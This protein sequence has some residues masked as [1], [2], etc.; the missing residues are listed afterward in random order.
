MQ[1]AQQYVA[2]QFNP[3]FHVN[4]TFL[5]AAALA[6]T[7]APAFAA[8]PVTRKSAVAK[9]VTPTPDWTIDVGAGVLFTP[10]FPGAKDNKVLPL[11]FFAINY[12]D[13]VFAS[14]R[15]GLGVNLLN[16]Y[17]FKA[18]PILKVGMGRQRS[19][20]KTYLRGLTD[21]DATLEGGAFLSYTLDPYFTTKVELRK[22]LASLGGGS[23]NNVLRGIGINQKSEAHEGVVADFSADFKLPTMFDN[24]LFFSAGPRL[25]YY[26]KDYAQSYFGVTA[27]EARVSRFATYVPKAGLGK[28]G[29]GASALYRISDNTS[30]V[31][32][33]DYGRLTGNVGK[34][35]IVRGSS[36]SRDQF[37]AGAAVTYRF[38]L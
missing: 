31:L 37:T 14:T 29:A 21:V 7:I 20:D 15:D 38:G 18:G 28:I 24:R 11:P 13:I 34:S 10:K 6:V 12:R 22:G 19:D 3:E 5:S 33:G 26:D 27:N 32:F 2:C 8:D 35:P 25:S 1:K 17:G 9:S 30:L 36:G 23:R 4:K 16:A